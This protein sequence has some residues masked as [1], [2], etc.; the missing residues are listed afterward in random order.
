M[1]SRGKVGVPLT[2]GQA[3]H[4]ALGAQHSTAQHAMVTR[5]TLYEEGSSCTRT[6]LLSAKLG[7]QQEAC[8]R[9]CT[10]QAG[11]GE[12]EGMDVNASQL[13]RACQLLMFV[14]VGTESKVVQLGMLVSGKLRASEAG[15]VRRADH[16]PGLERERA[17]V[18][19]CGGRVEMQRCWRIIST[20]RGTN[21]GLAVSRSLGDLDFKEPA[22]CAHPTSPPSL[23]AQL[24][25]VCCWRDSLQ[26]SPRGRLPC[27]CVTRLVAVGKR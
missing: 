25:A 24:L 18:E 19:G 20:A 4:L 3:N 16:K 1:L 26:A 27:S 8:C 13:Q 14:Q 22:M 12:G 9:P 6:T 17:R 15:R 21:T 23:P 11:A 2:E 5:V 10:I 7:C